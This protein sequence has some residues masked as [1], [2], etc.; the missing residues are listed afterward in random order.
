M[1]EDSHRNGR[2]HLLF[3]TIQCSRATT[4]FRGQGPNLR[5]AHNKFLEM[6]LGALFVCSVTNKWKKHHMNFTDFVTFNVRCLITIPKLGELSF[7]KK[8]LRY[9]FF[10]TGPGSKT[11]RTSP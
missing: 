7:S 4:N 11:I 8:G 1:W 3:F 10:W 6:Y 9:F 5:R 2:P